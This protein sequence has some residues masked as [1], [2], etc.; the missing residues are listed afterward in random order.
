VATVVNRTT[1]QIIE[2]VNSPDYDTIS[3][4]INPPGLDALLIGAIPTRYWKI[5]DDD[6]AEMDQ[7]EK[8]A[9]D[10][11][12]T[13]VAAMILALQDQIDFDVSNY[14]LTRYTTTQQV[15]F[16][17]LYVDGLRK[18]LIPRVEY[19]QGFF[20]WV[21]TVV[22]Y[23]DSLKTQV[24]AYTSLTQAETLVK[25]FTPFNA[26]DPNITTTNAMTIIGRAY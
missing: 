10:T 3:W 13:N 18:K 24:A 16:T 12:A 25:D 21:D 2:S 7:T 9:V 15:S 20:D 19:V 14:I 1:F 22:A 5:V 17:K 11:N 4:L 8:D 23:G 26:T 6:L